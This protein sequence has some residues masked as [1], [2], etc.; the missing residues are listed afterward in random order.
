MM[1]GKAIWKLGIAEIAKAYRQIGK[2]PGPTAAKTNVLAHVGL[3]PMT[4]KLYPSW[5]TEASQ[6]AWIN[7]WFLV[8]V[9]IY[10]NVF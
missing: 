2:D 10:F 5:K 6:S 8:N 7:P 4:I 9:P 3:W 1:L